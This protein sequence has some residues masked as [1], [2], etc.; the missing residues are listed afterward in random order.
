M[1][2]RSST[3]V[4]YW[5]LVDTTSKINWTESVLMELGVII[6][7]LATIWCDNVGTKCLID[8]LIFH[9]KIKHV[10]IQYHVIREQ[11]VHGT[12]VTKY[13]NTTQ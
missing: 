10:A 9:V 13:I 11:V 5:S 6:E 2:V 12:L 1:V 4:E 3:E 7:N 8:N